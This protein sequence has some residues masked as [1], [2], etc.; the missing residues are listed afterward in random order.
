M[1]VASHAVRQIW[2]GRS[3]GKTLLLL[4]VAV[5]AYQAY[6]RWRR[7]RALSR[8]RGKVVLI[9]GASS[10]LGEG[11][12]SL[13]RL[14]QGL[15]LSSHAALARVFYSVGAKV[16]LASRDHQK[17]QALKFQLDNTHTQKDVRRFSPHLNPHSLSHAHSQDPQWFS[18]KTLVLDLSLPHSLPERAREAVGAFGRVDILINNA[19]IS[20]RGPVMDT[21]LEVDRKVMETN[22][23][24]TISL[25][26][27][28]CVSELIQ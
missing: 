14:I 4:G 25:T 19:G 26:R 24:G 11:E 10:G 6:R 16:I 22:F 21:Q 7:R 9:T 8:L 17:L 5:V 12:G 2:G 20:S 1:E 3:L 13:V 28:L 23:F 15:P 27:G 18:P